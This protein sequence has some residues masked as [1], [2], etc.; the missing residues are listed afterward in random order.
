MKIKKVALIAL[1]T[2]VFSSGQSLYAEESADLE[3]VNINTASAEQLALILNGVGEQRAQA[4]VD[5]RER[6]GSFQSAN[7]L[8]SVKGIG[9]ATLEDNIKV[10]EF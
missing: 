3:K 4:I 7:D 9:Q 8:I 1:A 2:A 10:I 5:Y 6:H